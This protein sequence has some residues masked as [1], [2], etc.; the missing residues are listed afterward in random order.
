MPIQS[1]TI[2]GAGTLGSQIAFQTAFCGIPV[3]I[4]NPHPERATKRLNA[5]K[6]LYKRDLHA[7]D[8]QIQAA[9]DNIKMITNDWAKPFDSDYIIEA[10]PEEM[11]IKEKFYTELMKHVSPQT[12]IASNSSTFLPS[13]LVKFVDHP[14]RF[15]HMHF[16]NHIWLFNVSEIVGT[17]ATKPEVIDEVMVFAKRIKMLPIRLNKENPGYIM[18]ALSIP[19]L[20]AA[21]WLW[22]SGVA[23]YQTIDKDWMKASG[24]PMG[25]FMSLDAIG[26]RTAYAISSAQAATN[27]AAK[28]V[29]G[30][31][32]AMVDAGHTGT[33]AGEGFYKYPH[34]AYENPDFLKP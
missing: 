31:L 16:A 32:K 25:P 24:A 2:A 26:L 10:V 19:Y 14:E 15:L 18:N 1:L 21:L 8:E 30:K 4:W 34:P 11:A 6:P 20:N 3:N 22:A 27:P 23:D 12:I 17:P 5:L 13:Q 7:T 28:I 33:L 29:A 9:M